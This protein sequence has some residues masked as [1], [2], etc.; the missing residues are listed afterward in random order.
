MRQTASAL[1]RGWLA[2]IGLVLIIAAAVAGIAR[3]GLLPGIGRATGLSLR[4]PADGTKLLPGGSVWNQSWVIVVV[5]VVGVVLALLGL[6]WLIA[7]VPRTNQARPFRLHDSAEHGLT[8]CEPKVLTDAVETQTKAFPGVTDASAVLRGTADRPELTLKVTCADRADLS[9]LMGQLESTVAAG[10]G[11]ALDAP[12]QRFGVL[13]EV[14]R[15]RR[16]ER[17]VTV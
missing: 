17:A 12:V 16:S 13:V 11:Q 4:A 14:D 10:L 7:Q 15:S 5:I 9:G 1:N 2:V 6:A 8:R 3:A